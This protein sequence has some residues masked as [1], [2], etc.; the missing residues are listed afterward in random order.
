MGQ[1]SF[2]PRLVVSMLA[3]VF[4]TLFVRLGLWQLERAEYKANRYQSFV[5]RQ[6]QAPLNLMDWSH[7]GN[8]E[9]ML[10][11]RVV[12]TGRFDENKQ[13][14]L[15]NRV[16]KGQAGY[17][18]YTP[19]QLEASGQF[20]L[21]NRGWVAAPDRREQLPA[22]R[23]NRGTIT[24]RGDLKA[25]PRTGIMLADVEP[26][27]MENEIYRVQNI[28]LAQLQKLLGITLTPVILRLEQ[29]SSF[30]YINE[31]SLPGS[32]EQMHRGYAY[33]WF[34]FAATLALIYLL[35]NVKKKRDEQ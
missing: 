16:I 28:E 2:R 12:A 6:Q 22:L 23:K 11:R 29:G 7:V 31:W 34:A 26:E 17:F 14:L 27:V 25:E 10:W 35:L 32:N 9:D 33:Q 4:F 15:D 13:V 21:V 8:V 1:W 20:V 5:E 30:G 18:V 24:L 19:F 3:L